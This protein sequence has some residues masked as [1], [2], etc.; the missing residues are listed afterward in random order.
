[1]HTV[2]W[3]AGGQ[4]YAFGLNAHGQLGIGKPAPPEAYVAPASVWASLGIAVDESASTPETASSVPARALKNSPAKKSPGRKA[5][6]RTMHGLQS[7]LSVPSGLRAEIE[8]HDQQMAS[9][10][11]LA[12]RRVRGEPL[13]SD[14]LDES[15]LGSDSASESIS[16]D[17]P[18]TAVPTL[19]K[20]PPVR[21]PGVVRA[22]AGCW[23]TFILVEQDAALPFVSDADIEDANDNSAARS[24]QGPGA[25]PQ[26]PKRSSANKLRHSSRGDTPVRANSIKSAPLTP[27][28]DLL[29]SSADDDDDTVADEE[30]FQSALAQ[31]GSSSRADVCNNPLVFCFVLFHFIICVC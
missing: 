27:S 30:R 22:S 25:G 4:L 5:R 13:S 23:S 10:P 9:T 12:R 6:P 26:T 16:K 29:R 14:L 17:A 20:L 7:A 21:Q 8:K 1:M 3:T 18:W 19:V 31:L 11:T 15:L 24:E 28:K 2:V